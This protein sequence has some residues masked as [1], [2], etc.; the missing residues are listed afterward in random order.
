[1]RDGG[2][3]KV[4]N[5]LIQVTLALLAVSLLLAVPAAGQPLQSNHKYADTVQAG[6][7]QTGSDPEELYDNTLA[8]DFILDAPWRVVDSQT[9]IPVTVILK[10]CDT[11][12]IRELH[13]IRCTDVTAGSVTLWHHDYG[14]EEI[15]DDAPEHNYWTWITTVTEGHPS[16]AD[17]TLLTPANLGYGAGDR[18]DLLVEVYYRDDW[19]NYTDSRRLRVLV[20]DG[21]FP[22]P[23]GWY[24]GDTHYHTMYTNN[25]AEFGAPLPAVQMTAVSMGL[26]WLT[27]TDHSCDLDET[28]DGTYSYATPQWEYTIQ[29]P[30]G[31]STVYRNVTADGGT[32]A[33]LGVDVAALDGPDFRLY[34]GVEINLASVDDDSLDKTL[35][36]LF[37]NPSYIH[38]PDCGA[39]GERPVSPSLPN[40]LGQLDPDGFAYAAHPLDDLGSEFGI[41]VT[42]NGAAWGDQDFDTALQYNAF[43]GLEAFNTRAVYQSNDQNN[44]WGDFDTG[45]PADNAYPGQ[46]LDG[47]ALWDDLLAAEL[48]SG[49][50]RPVFL[51]GGSDA[52][53]DFNYSAYM[54]LDNYATDNAMGKVQTVV[55]VPGTYGPGNLPPITDLMDAFRQGQSV[56][57]DGPFLEI[58][59][60]R[61]GDGSWYGENDLMIGGHGTAAAGRSLTLGL[62][63]ASLAEFGPITEVTVLAV[64]ASGAWPLLEI[65]PSATGQGYAGETEL[66]L[67]GLLAEGSYFIR[68]QCLTSDGEAGHR[69]FTNPLQLDL[70]PAVDTLDCAYVVTPALGTLP[71]STGHQV[72][73]SNLDSTTTRRM[74]ARIHVTLGDGGQIGNWRAGYTNILPSAQFQIQWLTWLPALGTLLGENSFR[75]VVADVTPAPYNQPPYQPAGDTDSAAAMVN[76][77]AP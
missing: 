2:L 32:W 59:I 29:S 49:S 53:G 55:R 1:M 4:M 3:S 60:D 57:T 22:W 6:G 19:F 66:E 40:G 25:I 74:A 13:W 26:H 27:A 46:L 77:L 7:A 69:A 51:S 20:G 38:S 65:D 18:I 14:D 10:D 8:K 36:T 5:K 50:P 61:D 52:H 16:L 62:R 9:P 17:G 11:D 56:V 37:Y 67:T 42:V 35:H 71:F 39:I 76:A 68:A 30:A 23:D 64:S 41:D 63:W 44:P 33:G 28:G 12:D 48:A 70:V 75:L 54:S 58:G 21:P 15:G 24:G 72:T 31:I 47:I 73:I 45:Q 34:R 43:R